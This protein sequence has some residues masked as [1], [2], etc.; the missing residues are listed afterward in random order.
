[1]DMIPNRSKLQS[2]LTDAHKFIIWSILGNKQK[3]N[4][5]KRISIN[6]QETEEN[7]SEGKNSFDVFNIFISDYI[8][9]ACALA[10]GSG[11]IP[12][13]LP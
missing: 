8:Y 13:S 9:R 3:N 11:I 2:A 4:N 7:T 10:T 12:S 5:K 1:M 6:I